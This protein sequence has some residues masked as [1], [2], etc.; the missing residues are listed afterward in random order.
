MIPLLMPSLGT[1]KKILSRFW[2][3]DNKVMPCGPKLAAKS[4]L[5]IKTTTTRIPTELTDQID[6]LNIF[7]DNKGLSQ[8]YS[9]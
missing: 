2:K 9:K 7:K 4:L 1:V 6:D 8:R 3:C 5:I